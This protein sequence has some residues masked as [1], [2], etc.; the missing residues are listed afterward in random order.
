MELALSE[1][2][3]SFY[4]DR[5][6]RPWYLYND[7]FYL[8]VQAPDTP[9]AQTLLERST[10]ILIA[11][12]FGDKDALDKARLHIHAAASVA[13]HC[14]SQDDL[15]ACIFDDHR[16]KNDQLDLSPYDATI[17]AP[18][19]PYVAGYEIDPIKWNNQAMKADGDWERTSPIMRWFNLWQEPLSSTQV[20][21]TIGRLLETD[22]YLA[23]E[24]IALNASKIVDYFREDHEKLVWILGH[25]NSTVSLALF[26]ELG[27]SSEHT[28]RFGF[29]LD[30]ERV[31]LG[32]S[33]GSVRHV[34]YYAGDCMAMDGTHRS[35]IEGY[36]GYG[37]NK[38]GQADPG[39]L[40]LVYLGGILIGSIKHIKASSF[41]S[42]VTSAEYDGHTDLIKG[43]C[44]T[45]TRQV[46]DAARQAHAQ[47]GAWSR[48]E[49]DEI[50]L[51]P[52]R[53]MDY[54]FED[55]TDRFEET[56]RIIDDAHQR[57]A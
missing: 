52:M 36:E 46:V 24:F 54:H 31:P 8:P 16:T 27:E 42:F 38:R 11:E 28:E 29:L 39:E 45:P 57:F 30:G 3:L 53:F 35:A 37:L 43:A 34:N 40:T 15:A 10:E 49:L 13:Q 44:Y 33:V 5:S 23:Y 18:F 12:G 17:I 55:D 4:Q 6:N 22:E 14:S 51:R 9:E 26:N 1:A 21:E 41:L 47:Q 48:L 20:F 19:L 32:Q 56:R 2:E 25:I 7:H 50:S